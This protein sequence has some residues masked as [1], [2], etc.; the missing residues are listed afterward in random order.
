MLCFEVVSRFD[1]GHELSIIYE[2]DGGTLKDL[3]KLAL[4]DARYDAW[5]HNAIVVVNVFELG[6][7]KDTVKTIFSC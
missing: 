7:Y 4:S 1:N 3:Y 2:R 6:K 5:K